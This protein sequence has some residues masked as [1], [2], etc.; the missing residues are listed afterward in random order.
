ME[1]KV[2]KQ[3]FSIWES[4]STNGLFD[5]NWFIFLLE[6]FTNDLNTNDIQDA[7]NAILILE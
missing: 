5:F 1:T 7:E 2:N 6:Y 3:S 4:I